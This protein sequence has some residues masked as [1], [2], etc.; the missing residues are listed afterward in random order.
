MTLQTSRLRITGV[1]LVDG[2]YELQTERQ[3]IMNN[4]LFIPGIDYTPT[5]PDA[6]AYVSAVQVAD[7][8]P[9]ESSVK[10]AINDLVV[11]L[12][13]GDF[14][15]KLGV[16]Y[17]F[18][19]ARTYN[20]ALVPL[21]GPAPTN[22]GFGQDDY[23]RLWGLK[24]DGTKWLD[25]NRANDI[26]GQN[27]SHNTIWLHLANPMHLTASYYGSGTDE[28]SNQLAYNN[29]TNLLFR[30]R[31]TTS[32]GAGFGSYIIDGIWG[33][34]RSAS[35]SY[36]RR[37]GAALSGAG[38]TSQTPN[39]RNVYVFGR[40]S[41]DGIATE[42]ISLGRIRWYSAGTSMSLSGI[43]NVLR[44]Y[45]EKLRL[46]QP[47]SLNVFLIAGQSN[48][49]GR[50]TLASAPAYLVDKIPNVY[51]YHGTNIDNYYLNH[52][53]QMGNG[54]Y[55]SF[56]PS[57]TYWGPFDVT[58][59]ELAETLPNV[60]V[61]RV[62]AGGSVLDAVA[63][64][65]NANRGSWS[66]RFGDIPSGTPAL[67]QA[68]EQRVSSMI[69]WAAS[70]GVQLNFRGM[71][72]HQG[73]ADKLVGGSS[74][75]NYESNWQD[76]VDYIRGFTRAGF[77]II[78]GT[79]PTASTSFDATIKAAQLAVAA[80]DSNLYCRDNDDLAVI[81]GGDTTHFSAASAVTFGEWAAET[82]LQNYG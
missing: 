66:D 5:D 45:F 70:N 37:A 14:W 69:A 64:S 10:R 73:G 79:V 78:Y 2:V 34:S 33:A 48:A 62:S 20:G 15:D 7:N 23:H 9:L 26:D 50:N 1:N 39:S 61:L 76:V 17:L 52:Y 46:L 67:L 49:E 68:L 29:N 38:Q 54:A 60:C 11:D 63:P 74:I 6:K 71:L 31:S 21:R 24:S 77:P 72:W 59:K 4:I 12:K 35:G 30:N 25:S 55:W 3:T 28:G 19:G 65:S 75:T 41:S 42:T 36:S 82:W 44:P 16:A 58:M 22:T 40:N 81:G 43:E 53:R 18:A 51:M 27:D 56:N 8:Q 47:T 80:G 57:E 13:A 32:A